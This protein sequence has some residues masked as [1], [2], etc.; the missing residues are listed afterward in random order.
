MLVLLYVFRNLRFLQEILNGQNDFE[1]AVFKMKM[2]F[3]GMWSFL[4]LEFVYMNVQLELIICARYNFFCIY[5][6]F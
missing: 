1:F 4:I 5:K 2:V 3:K 6:S